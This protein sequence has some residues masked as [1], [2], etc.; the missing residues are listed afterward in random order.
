M[1]KRRRPS[2][3]ACDSR[4]NGASAR[5]R[6]FSPRAD[7][8]QAL[9][10]TA[11]EAIRWLFVDVLPLWA[12]VGHDG[13]HGGFFEQIA[14]DGDAIAMPKRCRVQARQAYV[15][16]EAGRL[17]WTGAWRQCADSGL[18][19][20]LTHHARPDGFMRFTTHVDGSPCDDS[21]DN[22]DQ[23][24]A[25]FALAHAFSVT[26][27]ER[28]RQSA[29]DIL[30]ALRRERRHPIGGFYEAAGIDGLLRSNPHMHLLEAALAWLDVDPQPAWRALAQEIADL[31]VSR[32]IQPE[33]LALREYFEADWTFERG[34]AGRVIEPGHQF[35]WAWLLARW[36]HHGGGVDASIIRGLYE[37]AERNGVDRA[38]SLTLGELWIDGGVKDAGAR[39][40][41]QTERMKAALAVARLWPGEREIHEQAALDAWRGMQHFMLPDRPG[42]FRDKRRAD[43]GFVEEGALASSLYHIVCAFSE[44]VRYTNYD[45]RR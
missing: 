12:S 1:F 29:L 33:K 22:Y 34:A 2:F 19:F 7:C 30:S 5:V 3:R 43:G 23:A 15:F 9:D 14:L 11:L 36:L 38:R 40:W 18:D 44:L 4:V 16:V 20:M 41:A 8:A 45:P 17:G 25:I 39:M 35:E 26:P 31:C 32:F 21:V 37:T 42:L 27:A 6:P 13:V 10:H 28:Y 24:F